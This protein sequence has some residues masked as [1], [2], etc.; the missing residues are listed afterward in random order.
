MLHS[1]LAK[2]KDYL[3]GEKIMSWNK[4]YNHTQSQMNHHANQCNPNNGSYRSARNN[5]ANQMNPNNRAYYS[6]R[7][8]WNR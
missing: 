7:S 3:E 1:R 5:R 2:L 4:N 8:N 6:S